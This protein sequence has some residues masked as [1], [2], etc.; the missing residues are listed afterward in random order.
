MVLSCTL[1]P[2]HVCTELGP[3]AEPLINAALPKPLK[4]FKFLRSELGHDHVVVD[5]VTVHKRFKD[6]VALDIDISFK[7]KPDI[8]MKV[9]PLAGAFGVEE[10]RWSGRLSVL[11]RP[12]TTT[13]PCVGA[14]QAAFVDHP[15]IYLNFSG[16]AAFADIGPVEKVVRKVMRDVV[17][18][19]FV[20]PNRFLF[21]LNDS[22]D[23][24]DLYYPPAGGLLVTIAAGRGF[25]KEKKGIIKLTP[26]CYC[27]MKF[28]LEKAQTPVVKKSLTPEWNT[29]KMFLLSDDDQPL[30]IK[31]LDDDPLS[32]DLLGVVRLT[33]SDLIS[34]TTR[35]V[36][37]EKDVDR[38]AENAEICVKSQ[39]YAF[40]EDL[41][42]PVMVSVLV[43]RAGKLTGRG[44]SLP[45][46]TAASRCKV[47]V[48]DK[49]KVSILVSRPAE[50]VPGVDPCNPTFNMIWDTIV[51]SVRDADVSISLM[52]DNRVAGKIH[53]DAATVQQSEGL[54]KVGEF[55][56]GGGVELRC[57]VILRGLTPDK[58][59]RRAQH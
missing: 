56:I 31:C 39:A 34:T 19:M 50:P 2:L 44:A 41:S 6:A 53:F 7:G 28:G 20:L 46:T 57:K 21:K 25:I 18:S 23:F 40:T 12:L 8:S 22:V 58:A 10:L 3:T 32:D 15:D 29:S 52:A 30:E 51:P 26:D 49:E 37:F 13:L 33:A 42:G 54:L 59:V 1:R 36:A 45:P 9:S 11:M 48:G 43:D 35:W 17:A 27:K 16:A 55:P 24:F 5:R 14:V 4:H 38:V 47:S